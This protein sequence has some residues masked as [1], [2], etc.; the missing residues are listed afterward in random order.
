[1]DF[2]ITMLLPPVY[3]LN[4]SNTHS[5]L[6]H[7][8]D[9]RPYGMRGAGSGGHFS[10]C[11]RRLMVTVVARGLRAGLAVVLHRQTQTRSSLHTRLNWSQR[12]AQLVSNYR[13]ETNPHAL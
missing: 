12:I 9:S 6:T 10:R 8:S 5:L 7:N 4:H 1:M 13:S 11:S 3:G 2:H